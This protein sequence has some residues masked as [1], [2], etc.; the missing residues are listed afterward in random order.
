MSSYLVNDNIYIDD[1]EIDQNII[2]SE[3]ELLELK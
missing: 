3:E 1:F 2:L